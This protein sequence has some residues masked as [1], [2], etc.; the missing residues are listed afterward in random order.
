MFQPLDLAAPGGF[1]LMPP[2]PLHPREAVRNQRVPAIL[3]LAR[4]AR[5]RHDQPAFRARQP[6]IE[7]PLAFQHLPFGLRIGQFRDMIGAFTLAPAP[8]GRAVLN[9][10]DL[11]FL[12]RAAFGSVGDDDDG[13]FQPLGSV[14]G[15]H[16]DQPL[17]L[18]RVAGL[19]ADLDI[20]AL[21]P[22]EEAGQRGHLG[23][24]IDQR[25]G[26]Q[27]VDAVLGLGAK[28]GDQAF[29]SL[30][31]GQ[32]AGD[33]V[34]GAKEPL[35]IHQVVQHRH[36]GRMFGA[37]AQALD[38][39]I[40]AATRRQP[41]KPFLAIAEQRRAQ[42]LGQRKVVLG[43]RHD[44]QGRYDVAHRQFGH[45]LQ[46]VGPGDGQPRGLQRADDLGEQLAAALDQHQHV[47]RPDPP[48]HCPIG[49]RHAGHA[50]P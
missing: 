6:H 22:D 8:D 36:R 17:A 1:D 2:H 19:A 47:A 14:D 42:R 39:V 45:Q 38:Q 11:A 46:P 27:F 9:M 12:R 43:R 20:V 23:P 13:A 28:A 7:Q 3:A 31:A 30:M 10:Q 48:R 40:P 41:V 50:D 49:V 18:G 16:P 25:L 35:V 26:Q 29:A 44:S 5:R 4:V 37:V 34:V 33:Q 32:Q 21:Q 24:L 15:H